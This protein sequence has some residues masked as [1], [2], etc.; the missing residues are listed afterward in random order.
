MSSRPNLKG[1]SRTLLTS[2][3]G[4][5]L[6]KKPRKSG[7]HEEEGLCLESVEVDVLLKRIR[8]ILAHIEGN[9][10][11]DDIRFLSSG[12]LSP[13]CKEAAQVLVQALVNDDTLFL[14]KALQRYNCATLGS[15][16]KLTFMSSTQ[17]LIN[18]NICRKILA[19]CA[20]YAPFFD[21]RDNEKVEEIG[22]TLDRLSNEN[23]LTIL[24]ALCQCLHNL[25]MPNDELA[26]IFAP[27]VL[28]PKIGMLTDDTLLPVQIDANY[29]LFSAADAVIE[30]MEFLIDHANEVFEKKMWK[31]KSLDIPVDK[32]DPELV[33]SPQSPIP[34]R[35]V[36]LGYETRKSF[37]EQT[38]IP[39]KTDT[40]TDRIESELV[41]EEAEDGNESSFEASSSSASGGS[42]RRFSRALHV[43]EPTKPPICVA[44]VLFEYTPVE[45]GEMALQ[46]GDTIQVL[47]IEED[48]WWLGRNK[49]GGIGIFPGG[50][51]KRL[52]PPRLP[53]KRAKPYV[54]QH[55]KKQLA[56]YKKMETD[57]RTRAKSRFQ[58]GSDEPLNSLFET[59]FQ[60]LERLE[61]ENSKFRSFFINPSPN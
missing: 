27:L 41:D 51:V 25:P 59:L 40:P 2:F 46:V 18:G 45:D 5:T 20:K 36:S 44:T 58:V 55:P 47:E 22:S 24:T 17:P 33:Q 13:D 39:T 37:P 1:M 42:S 9:A 34:Q 14:V 12:G 57:I 38:P 23:D 43:F 56:N 21:S 48:G 26:Y 11:A 10:E 61:E 49:D 29:E 16:V 53:A 7:S 35:N 32:K 54:V 50:Y 19:I 3:R 15:V 52:D 8:V 31:R 28:L 6:K 4:K 60:R 30:A